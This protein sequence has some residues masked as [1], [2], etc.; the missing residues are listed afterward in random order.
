MKRVGRVF[1]GK[2]HHW[3]L[4]RPVHGREKGLLVTKSMLPSKPAKS[5]IFNLHNATYQGFQQGNP[6]AQSAKQDGMELTV[7]SADDTFE[8]LLAERKSPHLSRSLKSNR[9]VQ[10]LPKIAPPAP[11]AQR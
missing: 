8:L 3:A 6:E 10:S 1:A 9:I 5:G 2:R 4:G 11:S 7:F